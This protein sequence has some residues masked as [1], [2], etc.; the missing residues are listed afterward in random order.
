MSGFTLTGTAK[1][2]VEEVWKLL[3]DPS[4]P[5]EWWVGVET[6]RVD[7]DGAATEYMVWPTACRTFRC[8]RACAPTGRTAVS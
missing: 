2:P 5:P 3:F 4:R 6:V 1:A 7:A 8:R